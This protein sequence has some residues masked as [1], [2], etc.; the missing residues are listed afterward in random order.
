MYMPK[1]SCLNV[2]LVLQV[3]YHCLYGL[4]FDTEHL[5]G[6]VKSIFPGIWWKKTCDI[7]NYCYSSDEFFHLKAI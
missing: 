1:S 6:I 5:S 7:P 3:K 2:M 4:L